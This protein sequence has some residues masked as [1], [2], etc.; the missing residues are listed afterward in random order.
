MEARA[1]HIKYGVQRKI[2]A[3]IQFASLF[4]TS[5]AQPIVLAYLNTML[6]LK[7]TQYFLFF[8][9]DNL[10]YVYNQIQ[11]KY[12]CLQSNF[13][14]TSN[15]YPHRPNMHSSNIILFVCLSYF[16]LFHFG[17]PLSLVCSAHILHRYGASLPMLHP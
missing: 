1:G 11:I 12:T 10:I 3:D 13:F 5:L 14:P 7:S 9:F 17:N 4:W 2:N 8:N 16:V 6:P 15:S